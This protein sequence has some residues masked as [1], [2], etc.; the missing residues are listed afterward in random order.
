MI[1]TVRLEKDIEKLLR[2]EAKKENKNI[3]D[4]VIKTLEKYH[5]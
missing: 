5:N 2:E 3:L 1:I 4:I